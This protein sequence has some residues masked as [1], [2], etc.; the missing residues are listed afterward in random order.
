MALG[1]H[2]LEYLFSSLKITLYNSS[3]LKKPRLINTENMISK[4]KPFLSMLSRL[5]RVYGIWDT[6]G[7]LLLKYYICKTQQLTPL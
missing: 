6:G 7:G 5:G 1:S 2:S 3:I 4:M